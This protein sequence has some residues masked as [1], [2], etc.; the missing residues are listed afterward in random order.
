MPITLRW[1]ILGAGNISSQFVHDLVLNNSRADSGIIHIVRS[2][3]CSSTSK[4]QD[5]IKDCNINSTNNE[6]IAPV[7]QSYDDFY[8][9]PEI[10]IVYVGTPH[11]FHKVQVTKSLEGGKHV[12]CEKPFTVN[13]KDAEKLF[14]LAKDKKLFLMEAVWTRFFPSIKLLKKYVYEDKVIGDVHRLFSD[15]AWNADIP[16]LEPTNRLRDVNLGGGSLLDIGIYSITY[17]RI[18]LDNAVGESHTKFEFKSFMSLDARDGVDYNTSIIVQYAD[19]KQG[20]LSCCN[21]TTGKMP[22]LRLEGTKGVVEMS[23]DNPA[24]PRQFKITFDDGRDPI[25]YK[26]ESG[27]NGFI[28]EANAV[29]RDIA[30]GKIENDTMPAAETLLVM[31]I[32]DKIREDAGL[33]YPQ[34]GQLI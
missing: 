14:Q 32:M 5:F 30:A 9:N 10:D 34:D 4:G 24:R 12:L 18:L 3:G 23:S 8:Q 7:V 27:Y 2:I 6:G 1:G 33:V 13:K 31:E 17:S 11:T 20:I 16:N 22:F 15:F 26:D 25:E 29:A 28:Y 19:G 21:Y